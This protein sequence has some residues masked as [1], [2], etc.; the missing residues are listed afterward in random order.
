[1]SE[2]SYRYY[3]IELSKRGWRSAELIEIDSIEEPRVFRNLL[4]S[5]TGEL[6]YSAE[7]P[8]CSV[9]TWKTCP[10]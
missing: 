5:H 3:Q 6:G 4:R 7:E 1:M 9:S 8:T 2:R 10:K